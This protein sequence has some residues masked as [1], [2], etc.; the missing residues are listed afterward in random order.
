MKNTLLDKY[1]SLSVPSQC[2][3]AQRQSDP[4]HF[5]LSL[6]LSVTLR[7]TRISLSLFDSPPPHCLRKL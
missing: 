2:A 5:F 1:R 6:S 3:I 4:L 7:G